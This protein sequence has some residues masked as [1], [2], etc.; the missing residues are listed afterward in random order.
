MGL[1]LQQPSPIHC[2]LQDAGCVPAL[3]S[4]R[5]AG[6]PADFTSLRNRAAEGT[7]ATREGTKDERGGAGTAAT[8]DPSSL[9]A[10]DCRT[11]VCGLPISF[12]FLIISSPS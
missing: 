11:I 5:K 9:Q 3:Y 12:L 4:G 6:I 8:M 1:V 2:Y 7:K 10:I